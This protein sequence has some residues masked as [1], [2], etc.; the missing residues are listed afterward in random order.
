MPFCSVKWFSNG[1]P[2]SW[3]VHSTPLSFSQNSRRGQVSMKKTV[4][5]VAGPYSLPEIRR[6]SEVLTAS[7]I[8]T[9]MEAASCHLF[10]LRSSILLSSLFSDNLCSFFGSEKQLRAQSK[11]QSKFQFLYFN[12]RMFKCE[13]ERQ[14]IQN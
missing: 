11:Q 5:W 1:K 7:I 6:R 4:F 9:I 10:F 13:T 2:V 8:R 3:S 12:L 14:K